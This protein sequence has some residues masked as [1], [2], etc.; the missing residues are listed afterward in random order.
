MQKKYRTHQ[1]FIKKNKNAVGINVRDILSASDDSKDKF[2][3]GKKEIIKAINSTDY[4]NE[5]DDITLQ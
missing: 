5:D 3:N 4:S 2:G 1:C